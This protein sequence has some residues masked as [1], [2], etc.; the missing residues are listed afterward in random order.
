MYLDAPAMM[1]QYSLIMRTEA[2]GMSRLFVVCLGAAATFMLLNWIWRYLTQEVQTKGEG[3]ALFSVYLDL[4]IGHIHGTIA[5][6]LAAAKR[7]HQTPQL[8]QLLAV[9]C[10]PCEQ[11]D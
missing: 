1:P 11:Y 9:G 6:L 8:L 7:L 2:T 3:S 10:A 5:A 4:K